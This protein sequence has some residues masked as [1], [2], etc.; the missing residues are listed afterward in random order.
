MLMERRTTAE[1]EELLEERLALLR[2][3]RLH[4]R[5]SA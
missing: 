5:R 2:S 1:L 3:G 4:G